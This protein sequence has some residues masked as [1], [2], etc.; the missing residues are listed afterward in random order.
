MPKENAA[1]ALTN[2]VG[3]DSFESGKS[4]TMDS[5]GPV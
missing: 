3:G 1:L 5:S 2:G 4:V